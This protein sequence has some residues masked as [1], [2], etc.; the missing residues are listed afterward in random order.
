MAKGDLHAVSMIFGFFGTPPEHM[1]RGLPYWS[2]SWEDRP[3]AVAQKPMLLEYLG[4]LGFNMCA[5]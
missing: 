5:P 3:R 4:T 1:W 2:E